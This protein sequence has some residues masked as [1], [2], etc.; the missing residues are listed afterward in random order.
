M[1][2]HSIATAIAILA[3]PLVGF[4]Q[5]EGDQEGQPDIVKLFEDVRSV[6]GDL[7]QNIAGLEE[8]LNASIDSREQGA[9][10]LDQMQASAEAV[11]ARLAEDSEIWTALVKA[12]ELWDD[13]KTEMLEKS[14]TNPAFKQ[15]AD[16]W[17]LK[18]EQASELRKQ[19]LTQRAESMALLDQIG[20]DREVVLAYYELGQADRALEAM[21]KVSGEL[22]RMNESMRAI[23]EQ[24]KEVAGPAVPQ[25]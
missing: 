17:A 22:G 7:E 24:T 12:M 20:A 25:Q 11:F 2:L 1:K 14:E 18:V 23:V 13:R 8:A 3:M 10:V 15:I 21:M 4:A 9:E 5:S 19:I 6:A 16:E